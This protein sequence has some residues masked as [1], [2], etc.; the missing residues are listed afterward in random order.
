MAAAAAPVPICWMLVGAAPA[1]EVDEEAAVEEA[2]EPEAVALAVPEEAEE[3]VEV[4]VLASAGSSLPHLSEML[5]VQ[6]CWAVE[7]PTLSALHS[8]KASSQT[9]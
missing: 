6:F 1:A 4:L 5:V 7:S 3:L 8:A 9:N 2:V